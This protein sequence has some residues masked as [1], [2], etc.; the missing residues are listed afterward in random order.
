MDVFELL[1][2][3]IEFEANWTSRYNALRNERLLRGRAKKK[4]GVRN[5]QEILKP[6]FTC[7]RVF[8]LGVVR[9]LNLSCVHMG[10]YMARRVCDIKPTL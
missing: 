4:R 2:S 5:P 9:V 3:V 8:F 6:K 10:R 1:L 7:L